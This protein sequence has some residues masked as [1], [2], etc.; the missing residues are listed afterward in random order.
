MF[1]RR[2]AVWFVRIT[3]FIP[4]L[5]CFKTKVYH[6]DKKHNSLKIKGKA[7]VASNHNTI[8][9]AAV[10]FYVL[11]RRIPRLLVAEVMY[12]KNALL[13]FFLGAIGCIKVNRDAHDLS[14]IDK[15]NKILDNGGLIEVYPESRLAKKGEQKPLPFKP[16]TVCMALSSGA[17]I[18]PVYNNGKYYGKERA[19]VIIGKPFYARDYYDDNL[20]ERE[21]AEIISEKL[22]DR[23]IELKDELDRRTK[24]QQKQKE[25]K[26]A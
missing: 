23:I 13:T 18:I 20:S 22:R 7:I 11:W 21:N 4:Y 19:R 3:G 5:F 26:E 25:K 14:F 8:M 9:D 24:K 12:K 6:E 16:S 17:P 2:I 15:C 1:W 10:M